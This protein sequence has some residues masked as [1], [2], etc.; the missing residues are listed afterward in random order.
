V[1]RRKDARHARGDALVARDAL[2][3]VL[4]LPYGRGGEERVDHPEGL[5]LVGDDDG[6][7]LLVVH[8]A[9]DG[10]RQRGTAVTADLYPLR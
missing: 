2:E 8:D 10:Q 4:E 1:L 6:R 3:V 7:A 9:P 5:A